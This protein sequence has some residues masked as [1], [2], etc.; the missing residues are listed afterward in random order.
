MCPSRHCADGEP[1]CAAYSSEMTS[2]APSG[3]SDC[4][5][6]RGAV[7]PSKPSAGAKLKESPSASN[8]SVRSNVRIARL[9]GRS[10]RM[11]DGAV[12]RRA[13]LPGVF[14]QVSGSEFLVPRLPFFPTALQL[15]CGALHI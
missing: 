8:A 2:L 10:A 14:P 4:S 6:G 9:L 7:V 1:C 11:G 15:V 5:V 3:G 12:E 13:H